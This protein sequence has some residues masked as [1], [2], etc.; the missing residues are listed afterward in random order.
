MG[1]NWPVDFSLSTVKSVCCWAINDHRLSVNVFVCVWLQANLVQTT[2]PVVEE[3]RWKL[4]AFPGERLRLM[5]E[6]LTC[7]HWH[8]TVFMFVQCITVECLD[9][10]K[11]LLNAFYWFVYFFCFSVLICVKPHAKLI[12]GLIDWLIACLLAMGPIFCWWYASGSL[13]RRLESFRIYKMY[14]WVLIV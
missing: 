6:V 13:G 10:N 7:C 3:D 8:R 11:R 5:E 9:I 2:V 4:P 14:Y 12:D 1:E